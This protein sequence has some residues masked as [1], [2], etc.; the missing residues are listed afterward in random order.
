MEEIASEV[1]DRLGWIGLA[2]VCFKVD[3]RTGLPVIHEVN[4]RLPQFHGI[5]QAAGIDLP[6]LMYLDGLRGTAGV[7]SGG[8]IYE[9][10]GAQLCDPSRSD[11]RVCMG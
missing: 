5:A 8:G 7:P 9:D 11:R 3:S 4:G 1:L 2:S 10:E 6:F